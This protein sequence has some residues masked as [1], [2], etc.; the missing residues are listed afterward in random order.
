MKKEEW[1]NDILESVSEVKEIEA[2]SF[3]YQKVLARLNQ[4]EKD[5]IFN[6]KPRVRWAITFSLIIAFN[7][8]A[9]VIHKLNITRQNNSEA[10]EVLTN[11]INFNTTYNY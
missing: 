7:L 3:L 5:L 8:S 2:N 4:Q 6:F 11:E 9:L 10:I 1:I